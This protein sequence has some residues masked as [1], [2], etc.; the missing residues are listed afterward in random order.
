MMV[1]GKV[2]MYAVCQD[3]DSWQDGNFYDRY[4]VARVKAVETGGCVVEVTFTYDE[5]DLVDD[6]RET[7]DADG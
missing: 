2:C 7:E 5:S 1:G 4:D 3:P 6:F